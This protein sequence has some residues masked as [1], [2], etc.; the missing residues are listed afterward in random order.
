MTTLTGPGTVWLQGQP[1][2]RLI[3][4][5]ARR[6]PAGLGLAVPLG[7]GGGGEEG[8]DGSEEEE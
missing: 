2:Q 7:V 6:V 4:E 8:G 1:P 3:S 5:I